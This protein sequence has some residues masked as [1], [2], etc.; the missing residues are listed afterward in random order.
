MNIFVLDRNPRKAA[1]FHCDKHVVKMILEAGQ[2]LCTAHWVH[3]LNT[4][5]KTIKDF[6]RVKDAKQHILDN[7]STELIPP[8]SLTHASHPC[9]VWT[10]TNIGNYEWHHHLMG[11]LLLEYT[12]RY[13]K[14]HKSQAVYRWLGKNLPTGMKLGAVTE[15]PQCMPEEYK[16]EGDA[17]RAY[18]NYYSNHKSYMARWKLGN[19]PHWYKGNTDV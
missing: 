10:A 16:V 19:V 13:G 8:W 6:K 2:M 18:R 9:A 5:G 3:S 4:L 17:V 1:R 12:A 14:I 7:T 11:E 15:H